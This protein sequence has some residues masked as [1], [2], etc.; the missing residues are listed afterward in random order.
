[1]ANVTGWYA[2]V[3]TAVTAPRMAATATMPSPVVAAT[4]GYVDN[5]NRSNSASLGASWN[6]NGVF[7]TS[8]AISSNAAVGTAGASNIYTLP[9]ATGNNEI[10]VVMKGTAGANDLVDLVARLS[11]GTNSG[12]STTSVT[13][14]LAQGKPWKLYRSAG[15]STAVASAGNVSWADA[16]TITFSA[17]GGTLTLKK[18]G[19]TI[20]TTSGAT[21]LAAGYVAILVYSA[22]GTSYGFDSFQAQDI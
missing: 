15:D 17:V 8:L 22:T 11:N 1:M 4:G 5:F 9:M 2:E 19:S 7:G 20:V 6:T 21:D 12:T 3:S 16:D 10:T 14:E 13:A 18:N